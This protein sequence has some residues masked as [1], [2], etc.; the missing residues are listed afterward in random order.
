MLT[1]EFQNFFKNYLV[2]N[3][4]VRLVDLTGGPKCAIFVLG[5]IFID[6]QN[7]IYRISIAFSSELNAHF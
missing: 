2:K 1:Q 5:N 3:H 4:S 6:V 7:L